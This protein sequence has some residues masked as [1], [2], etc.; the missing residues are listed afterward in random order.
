MEVDVPD[1]RILYPVAEYF[2]KG[3]EVQLDPDNVQGNWV[4]EWNLNGDISLA[5]SAMADTTGKYTLTVTDENNCVSS[6]SVDLEFQFPWE[7]DKILLATWDPEEMKN[8]VVWQKT[9]EKRTLSYILFRGNDP[10]TQFGIAGFDEVNLLVDHEWD[11]GTGP[12]IYNCILKDACDNFS[13][14]NTE[15]VHKTLHLS[16][17]VT[18]EKEAKLTWTPYEGFD[19]PFFDI[20]RGTNPDNMELIQTIENTGKESYTYIDPEGGLSMFYY[21]VRINTPEEI[22]LITKPE[23]KAGAGPF[24]HSF[25]NLEDNQYGTSTKE[26]FADNDLSVFPNPYSDQTTIRYSLKQ[27]GNLNIEVFNLLGQRV[28]CLFNGTHLR[29][30]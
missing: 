17:E 30:K 26:V 9:P 5:T 8:I 19:Y 3:E 29:K 11:P 14:V 24:V 28:A 1:F 18:P 20:L 23:K 25:S 4:Y 7:E 6:R 13:T 16:V 10:E 22:V 21:Q 27:R 15:R 12:A 2:C